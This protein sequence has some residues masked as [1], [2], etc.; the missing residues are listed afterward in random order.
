MRNL[1]ACVVEPSEIG[2]RDDFD[3]L[4]SEQT[5]IVVQ[6]AVGPFDRGFEASRCQMSDSKAV[7]SVV[8]EWI[9]RTQAPR[10][11]ESFDRCLGLVAA[12]EDMSFGRPRHRR[13]RIKRD[14]A[15][16]RRQSQCRLASEA[17]QRKTGLP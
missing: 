9:E 7:G 13:V 6:R 16:K 17:I 11:I 15:I 2:Q 14:G 3:L 4:W 8:T 12:S 5:W 1:G 10:A